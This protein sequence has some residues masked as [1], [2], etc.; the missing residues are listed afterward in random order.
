LETARRYADTASRDIKNSNES[1]AIR[2]LDAAQKIAEEIKQ[3]QPVQ[4]AQDTT[5][6]AP[7]QPSNDPPPSVSGDQTG[8]FAYLS[9]R[10]LA[11][12]YAD[13]ASARFRDDSIDEATK[14]LMRAKR[15][16]R[17]M[18][19]LKVERPAPSHSLV[20]SSGDDD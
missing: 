7:T 9:T 2:Y 10:R 8:L 6:R 18:K 16:V 1:Q 14:Y 3:M 20:Y 15:A 4:E 12:W 5:L 17:K 11:S 19:T 13:T